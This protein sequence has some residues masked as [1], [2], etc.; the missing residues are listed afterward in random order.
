MSFFALYWYVLLPI[1]FALFTYLFPSKRRFIYITL[2]Q[3]LLTIKII[4]DFRRIHAGQV[5]YDYLS[6]YH[7]GIG[8]SLKADLITIVLLA[9]TVLLFT[10]MFLYNYHKS[11]MSPLFLFLFTTF[12]GLISGLFLSNDLFNIY[13]IIE[14]STIVASILI[15]FKKDS[16]SIYNGM[17]YLFTSLAAMTFFLLGIGLLYRYF[18]V[19]DLDLLKK[20]MH[21]LSKTNAKV[22]ILPFSLIMTG[23]GLKAAI[24][25]LFSWLP[26]AHGTASAPSIVSAI[27]SAL[28]VKSGVYLFARF[29]YLFND[30]LDVTKLF[31]VLG[32]LTSIVG[33]IFALSQTD[34]KLIL[35]YHT[36]SQIGLIILGMSIGTP[37]AFWGGFYH[38]LNHAI[39]KSTLFLTAG[40]IVEEYH[41]RDIRKVYSLFQKMPWVAFSMLIAILGITGAPLFNGSISKYLIQKGGQHLPYFDLSMFIINLGTILS[42]VKYASMFKAPLKLVPSNEVAAGV[43]KQVGQMIDYSDR[44]AAIINEPLQ[45]PDSAVLNA[46]SLDNSTEIIDIEDSL[47]HFK[48]PINQKIVILSLAGLTFIG[49]IFGPFF[50]NYLFGISA[51]IS[52]ANYL[53]KFF[54]YFASLAFGY[55][56]YLFLYQRIGLFRKIREIELSFNQLMMSMFTFFLFLFTYLT[57]T[58]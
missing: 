9:L 17:I 3:L 34:I 38:L 33:F 12:E 40:I 16:R 27:L 50:I 19:L 23:I 8:I 31:I 54:I 21:G 55:F 35:A 22:L 24:M 56:F 41:T 37:Q 28:Y 20:E 18:G 25:P 57:L 2:L 10:A 5:V 36:V 53:V 44:G 29:T 26:K 7:N 47:S 49:G 1:I 11:Y 39:F 42:F 58:Y 6:D 45:T 13:V 32:F 14:V 4:F 15:I 52:L 46:S 48:L 43:P 30:Y 51:N